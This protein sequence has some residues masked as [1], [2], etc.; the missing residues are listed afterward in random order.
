MRECSIL[1]IVSID[2]RHPVPLWHG[3]LANVA[4]ARPARIRTTPLTHR[5]QPGS[6]ANQIGC[7]VV[8]PR[9]EHAHVAHAGEQTRPARCRRRRWPARRAP[10]WPAPRI[11]CRRRRPSCRTTQRIVQRA[12]RG[13]AAADV[14][15]SQSSTSSS[16][17]MRPRCGICASIQARFSGMVRPARRRAPR[18][19]NRELFGLVRRRPECCSSGRR[20]RRESRM[21]SASSCGICQ[22]YRRPHR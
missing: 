2:H 13:A 20:A 7:D 3:Q 9:N 5:P 15:A 22:W 16:R 17:H 12:V 19:G 8:Q 10:P 1:F 4:H 21:R 11:R 6:L 18:R 14:P